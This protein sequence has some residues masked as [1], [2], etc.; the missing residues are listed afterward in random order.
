MSSGTVAKQAEQAKRTK[1]ANL[2]ASHHF[3]CPV[4]MQWRPQECWNQRLF[5]IPLGFRTLAHA[6]RQ[7]ESESQGPISFSC[8]V[9]VS[10]AA[11]RGN[12]A[13]V[14]ATFKGPMD[15]GGDGF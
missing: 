13:A 6:R 15:L 7:L 5:S 2:D 3:V 11:Q 14:L 12:A 8:N 9:R 10:V 1:Y 4:G